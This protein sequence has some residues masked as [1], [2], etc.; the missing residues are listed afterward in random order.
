MRYTHQFSFFLLALVQLSCFGIL[1][2]QSPRFILRADKQVV[3][4]GETFVL[5]AVMENLDGDDVVFPDIAP[6]QVVQG[7]MN[8]S[9]YSLINGKRSTEKSLQYVLVA[10]R[11]GRFTL[12]PASCKLGSK[13]LKSNA[14]A[15]TVTGSNAQSQA[16]IPPQGIDRETFVALEISAIEGWVGQQLLMDVVLYTRQEVTSYNLLTSPK[17]DAFYFQPV[18]DLRDQFREVKVGGKKYFAHILKRDRLFARKAGIFEIEP[19]EVS[20]DMISEGNHSFFFQDVESKLFR[21]NQVK[22]NIKQLPEPIPAGFSGA[23]GEYTLDAKLLNSPQNAS[24]ICRLLL[25]IEGDGDPKAWEIPKIA[26]PEVVESYEPKLIRDEG[27]PSNGVSVYQREVEYTFTS[28][29][30]TN[31]VI[32]A[33]FIY[34]SPQKASFITITKDNPPVMLRAA[35]M[36]RSPS[37]SPASNRPPWQKTKNLVHHETAFYGSSLFYASIVL[38]LLVFLVA[39]LL[40]VKNWMGQQGNRKAE[41]NQ[42]EGVLLSLL[43]QVESRVKQ[44]DITGFYDALDAY[45][46][47]YVKDSFQNQVPVNAE[48][49]TVWKE[50]GASEEEILLLIQLRQACELARYAGM[51]GN[52]EVDLDGAKKLYKLY[53]KRA[54]L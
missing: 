26:V 6:F 37:S 51:K 45:Y 7:P 33:E 30:D 47:Y 22:V 27:L 9:Q 19:V 35:A 48:A 1:F 38:A 31:V 40:T 20:L 50:K 46:Q 11:E 5:E 25:T 4:K 34:F 49:E 15:I 12:P 44:R 39:T 29:R 2:S 24:E 52:M 42:M 8:S 36:G 54:P 28:K 18:T 16:G 21:T 23:V 32:Q 13:T 14:L 41:E 43:S 17:H 53:E 3:A 10:V